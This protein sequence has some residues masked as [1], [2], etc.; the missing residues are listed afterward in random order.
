VF[1]DEV[2]TVILHFCLKS[3]AL[4]LLPDIYQFDEKLDPA[5]MYPILTVRLSADTPAAQA[6][7]FINGLEV[8]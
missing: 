3:E 8:D 1:R 4:L 7:E 2:L 6:I 5:S